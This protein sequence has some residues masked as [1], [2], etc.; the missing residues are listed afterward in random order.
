MKIKEI[1]RRTMHV[2]RETR[3]FFDEL[4]ECIVLRQANFDRRVIKRYLNL[5]TPLYKLWWKEHC[6]S[7]QKKL[8]YA[9]FL[10]ENG[11]VGNF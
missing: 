2:I 11:I 8:D 7:I 6:K 1:S 5:E 9:A 10:R 4:L 3:R